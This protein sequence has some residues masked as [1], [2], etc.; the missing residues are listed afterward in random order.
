MQ[1]LRLS[2]NYRHHISENI[3]LWV[4]TNIN[5]PI[6]GFEHKR[7]ADGS[8]Y[9]KSQQISSTRIQALA[10]ATYFIGRGKSQHEV[11]QILRVFS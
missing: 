10:V 3:A 5:R 9:T 6:K 7:N 11:L 2:P 8:L 1:Q 4:Q